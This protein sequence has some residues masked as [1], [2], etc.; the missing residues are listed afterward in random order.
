MHIIH[1]D[2][3]MQNPQKFVF[4]IIADRDGQTDFETAFGQN[5]ELMRHLLNSDVINEQLI[6][7]KH[8]MNAFGINLVHHRSSEEP[9][10]LHAAL[11]GLNRINNMVVKIEKHKQK[12]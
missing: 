7:G 2:L 4:G 10:I 9:Q 6:P 1:A 8:K 5:V 11:A 12:H 3:L